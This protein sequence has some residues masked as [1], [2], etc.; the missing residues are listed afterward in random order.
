MLQNPPG[1]PGGFSNQFSGPMKMETQYIAQD[2]FTYEVDFSALAAGA[3][4][5]SSIQ[6]ENSSDFLWQKACFFADIAQAA[7]TQSSQ[8][9]P[10]A[11]VLLTDSGSARQLMNSAVP[12]TSLFG[13]GYSPFILTVPKKFL[14]RSSIT[15][16]VTNFSAATT[17]NIRLSF[18]GVK[19]FLA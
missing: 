19:L 11:T 6:I 1:S 4:Q 15:V 2:T 12:I 13:V 5:S 10:L 7:Q 14:A 16:A 18:I 9:M 8:V 3:S 17:Y